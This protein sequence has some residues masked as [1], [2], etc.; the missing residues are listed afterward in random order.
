MEKSI[1]N[2]DMSLFGGGLYGST[3]WGPVI[4][5]TGFHLS[6]ALLFGMFSFR[7]SC[8]TYISYNLR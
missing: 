8:P 1:W 3:V 2:R 5:I 7:G 4:A 6:V